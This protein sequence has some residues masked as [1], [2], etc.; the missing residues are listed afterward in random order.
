MEDESRVVQRLEIRRE[1]SAGFFSSGGGH[2]VASC[3]LLA[4]RVQRMMIDEQTDVALCIPFYLY[5][6][7]SIY[8][9]AGFCR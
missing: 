2:D 9:S 3:L 8:V 7:S 4:A 1:G 6:S 5:L